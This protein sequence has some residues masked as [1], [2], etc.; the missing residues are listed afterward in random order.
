MLFNI[1]R[2]GKK[3]SY[4]KLEFSHWIKQVLILFLTF[5]F[6]LT[7]IPAT[8]YGQ[9]NTTEK[10]H[11]LFE[12]AWEYKLKTN[13][14]EAT[15]IGVHKYNDRLPDPSIKAKNNELQRQQ[16]FLDQ[17]K[18]IDR[19]VLSEENKLNYDLFKKIKERRIKELEN[20]EYLIPINSFAGFHTVFPQLPDYMP[21]Q[22]VEG[23]ENYISRLNAFNRFVQQQITVMGEGLDKGFSLPRVIASDIPSMVEP[24]IV[25]DPQ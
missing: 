23:Y 10:L 18:Q 19:G 4:H 9:E 15:Y 20:Q 8:A 6:G 21:L 7:I 5:C 11:D 24:H 14:L 22:S 13:P 17:L 1:A 3:N 12:K 25:E 16:A 2:S